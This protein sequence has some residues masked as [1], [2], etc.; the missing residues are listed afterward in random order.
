MQTFLFILIGIISGV[1]GGMG[2]G[3]GT[4]LIPLLTIFFHVPQNIAQSVNLIAFIPMSIVVTVINVKSKMI[5][6]KGLIKMII[7]AIFTAVVASLLVGRTK[8]EI[9]QKS[10]GIFLIVVGVFFIIITTLDIIKKKRE[11]EKN[12]EE[13]K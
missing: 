12:K 10:Y 6:K 2:M 9:L 1:L 11:K 8:N 13:I 7:P 5:E 4:I 3:G